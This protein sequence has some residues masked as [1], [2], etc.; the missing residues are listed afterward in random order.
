M[1]IKKIKLINFKKFDSLHEFEFQD[2]NL[3][4]GANGSGKSSVKDA[5][6]F[7]FYNRTSDG[8]LSESTRY[9]SSDK[10]K[11]LVEIVFEINGQEHTIRR[12]RTD[13]QTRIT[14]RDNS[15]AE[16]DSQI[17][18][19]TLESMIPPYKDFSAVF[20]IGWFMML[21][22]REKRDY[23]LN[24]T[25]NISKGELFEK[26][27]G[28]KED[29]EKFSLSFE[30][31]T[32]THNILL[33]TKRENEEI[34]EALRIF[35]RD[36]VP[37]EIPKLTVVDKSE[38]LE[39]LKKENEKIIHYTYKVKEYENIKKH[40]EE[41]EANNK[42]LQKKIA[43]IKIE[44]LKLPSQDKIN[45]LIAKKN[46]LSKQIK[47]PVGTCPTCFQIIPTQHRTNIKEINTKNVEL[48]EETEKFLQTEQ[49]QYEELLKKWK[50][51]E[52]KKKI[53]LMYESQFSD[54]LPEI[55]KPE[56]VNE[57]N[58]ETLNSLEENQKKLIE[59]KRDVVTLT[60]QE[61]I[62][63]K[64]IEENKERIAILTKEN[65]R[66]LLLINI[67]S[68]R[69][70]PAEEMNIKLDPIKKAFQTLLP[71]SDIITIESLKNEMGYKEVFK[72]I[73][74]GKEYSKLSLGEKTRVDI[75]IS[76]IINSMLKEK[77]DVFFLDNS[78]V[79]D[80]SI[81]LPKQSFICK[82][83]NQQLKIN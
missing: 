60:N 17:T 35:N 77:I 56:K 47:L 41:V 46:E 32:R 81:S 75:A 76:Q 33:K 4:T 40:N 19:E 21:N 31:I 53:K 7:C 54:P 26:L 15:Q 22:D 71:N 16:E 79:L 64:K 52:E 34:S 5:I 78:E 80:S 58:Q 28:T 42:E 51:N 57:L 24:L 8:S 23:M 70:I 59:E 65:E 74:E 11:C 14:Y 82:V 9:I 2:N 18:Q 68:P 1:K 6:L 44:D 43:E 29:I 38:E 62:R 83:T 30:D 12:E 67:F 20:N 61:E 69:G 13:R 45:T 66:L 10:L 73:V 50:D 36:S 55:E 3:I 72:I 27:G 25:P 49:R 37:V 48:L 39:R 63:L